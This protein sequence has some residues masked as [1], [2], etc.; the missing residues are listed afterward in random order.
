VHLSDTATLVRTTDL[1]TV[2]T[3]GSYNDL[4]NQ[5]TI[6]SSSDDLTSDHNG[7][8]YTGALNASLTTHLAGIDTAL[9]N[10]LSGTSDSILEGQAKVETIDTGAD[11]RI[12]FSAD[13][14]STGTEKIW[15]FTSAGHLHP[16]LNDTYDIGSAE[17]KVRDLYL[18]TSTLYLGDTL[19]LGVVNGNLRLS[20]GGS[21]EVGTE[22]V[23]TQADIPQ[24]SA[25]LTDGADLLKTTDKGTNIGDLVE[26]VDV[27]GSTS[28]LSAL[29]GS[30]LT[31][32]T[33]GNITG[34]PTI[35]TTSDD[36]T[37]NYNA[38]SYTALEYRFKFF[39]HGDGTLRILEL[40]NPG[41]I[42]PSEDGSNPG[43]SGAS[44]KYF[45]SRCLVEVF[46]I[47]GTTHYEWVVHDQ[48]E[49]GKESL[50]TAGQV[51]RYNPTNDQMTALPY[52][53]P[54][55]V[56][57]A[58]QILKT[59]GVGAL[60]FIDQPS[61]TQ[62]NVTSASPSAD[63]TISTHIGIEEIYVLT[64]SANISVFLPGASECGS[65]YKYHIKNMASGFT[66]TIDANSSETIDG[67]TTVTIANQYEAL[68]LVTD[69]SNW[70]II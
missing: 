64:P 28:G 56:G 50:S 2:A 63:Y 8:N 21:F 49:M 65:G 52:T 10:A 55:S 70:F 17:K 68:T 32:L 66:L 4:L 9:G 14:N 57:S 46:S 51:L 27:G 25:D 16:A 61:G 33:Y 59:D 19:S 30:N 38:N 13:P 23:L 44:M 62:P 40:N 54:T 53:F 37:G 35:P 43:D 60:T 1:A 11:A 47:V 29:D 15:E 69:G 39:N 24:S 67:S 26:V 6:P 22:T 34:T 12:E 36:L 7:T 48:L 31:N 5:P 18:G 41:L 58:G 3:S 42:D 20:G 45:N